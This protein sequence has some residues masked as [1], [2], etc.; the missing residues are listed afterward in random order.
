M[1]VDKEKRRTMKHLGLIGLGGLAGLAITHFSSRNSSDFVE[2]YADSRIKAM[3]KRIWATA[4]DMDDPANRLDYD[5]YLSQY[6]DTHG[7]NIELKVGGIPYINEVVCAYDVLEDGVS[8]VGKHCQHPCMDVCPTNA[9]SI[10][11]WDRGDNDPATNKKFPGFKKKGKTDQNIGM[12]S[13]C[14]G[15]GKCFKICGYDAIQWVN[16]GGQS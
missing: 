14:I 2:E 4:D 3:K 9:L 13:K 12:N 15:C 5:A 16:D 8:K 10:R 1:P 7:K 6:R 11:S